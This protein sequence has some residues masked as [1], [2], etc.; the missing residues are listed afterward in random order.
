MCKLCAGWVWLGVGMGVGMGEGGGSSSLLITRA[1]LLP[2]LR[3][4]VDGERRPPSSSSSSWAVTP[5][6]QEWY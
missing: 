1:A 5:V 6:N 3:L 2:W 4:K